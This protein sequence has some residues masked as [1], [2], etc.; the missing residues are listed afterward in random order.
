MGEWHFIIK[1][2]YGNQWPLTG[3]GKRDRRERK[4]AAGYVRKKKKH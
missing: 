4:S 3:G 1:S 2:M